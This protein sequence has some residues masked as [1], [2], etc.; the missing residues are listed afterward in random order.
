MDKKTNE[1]EGAFGTRHQFLDMQNKSE[2][3]RQN[4]YVVAA[5]A[6]THVQYVHEGR[7]I[8][9]TLQAVTRRGVYS[10][11]LAF[12]ILKSDFRF[13]PIEFRF[14]NCTSSVWS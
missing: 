10:A 4:K 9:F 5:T 7:N 6:A 8:Q 11:C 3:E 2:E 14:C 1:V 13:L 12:A